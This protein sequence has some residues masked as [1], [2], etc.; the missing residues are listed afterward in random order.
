MRGTIGRMKNEPSDNPYGNPD[1]DLLPR[2]AV[3]RF[4]VRTVEE[5]KALVQKTLAF[6]KDQR[7][8]TWRTRMTILA[9]IPAFNPVVDRLVESQAMA[10]FDRLDPAWHGQAIYHNPT[11]RFCVADN[12]LSLQAKDY[13]K[14]GQAFTFYF[15]HSSPEGFYAEHA[16][17]LDRD[18]WSQ[19]SMGPGQGVFC[20]F[21]CLGCQLQGLAGEGYGVAAVRNPNGPV[22]VIGSHGIC[23]AAMVQLAADALFEK[24]F[25]GSVP[26]RLGDSWLAMKS[27]LAK[28]KIDALTYGLLDAVDGDRRIPQATQRR[29]HLEM[30]TLLG[31]PA[32]RLPT[33]ARD[34]SL[35]S[36]ARLKP[37][38]ELTVTGQAPERLRGGKVLLS[39][40]RPVSSVPTGLETLPSTRAMTDPARPGAEEHNRILNANHR[41]ANRFVLDNAQVEIS[42]QD[43]A[44]TA[45]LSVPKDCPWPRLILRAYAADAKSE[46]LGVL[47]LPV[48]HKAKP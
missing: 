34:L 39:L 37:G 33:V 35:T 9:G 27:G 28:G 19:L 44:F 2:V 38:Q 11:S 24:T 42:G 12:R 10:R 14:Q 41:R 47:T 15:G 43:G 18:D 21:G 7:P 17:Y 31:D 45:R 26:E 40:E 20:T 6:E 29:E 32:L 5:A 25:S 22:A 3:G 16:H 46:A 13:L 8:A 30:F 4:P 36:P 48:T 23:F 1:R